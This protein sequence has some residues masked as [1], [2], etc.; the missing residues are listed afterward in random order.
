MW[1][2]ACVQ[3]VFDSMIPALL[4]DKERKFIFV[5]HTS[6]DYEHANPDYHTHTQPPLSLSLCCILGTY[7][8]TDKFWFFS[9]L[10]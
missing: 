8:N 10:N 3:N 9:P 4:T 6:P 7:W 2:G 5:E 1:Q